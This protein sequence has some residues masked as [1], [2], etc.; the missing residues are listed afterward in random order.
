MS[1]SKL[2]QKYN[3]VNA[4][5][6]ASGFATTQTLAT[7][8]AT[9]PANAGEVLVFA[10]A[11]FHWNPVGAATTSFMHAVQANEPALVQAH[12]VGTAQFIGDAGA[13]ILRVVYFRGAGR[14]DASYAAQTRPF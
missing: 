7:G 4:E 9:V 11:A 13:V 1:N 12:Q 5:T 8:G 10:N 3:V 6:L 2:R 14:Q